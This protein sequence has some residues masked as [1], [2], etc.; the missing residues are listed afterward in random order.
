MAS[1]RRAT[2]VNGKRRVTGSWFYN[3]NADRFVIILYRNDRVTGQCRRIVV[4]G[5]KPEWG[6]WRLHD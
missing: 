5:D 2:W 4:A 1:E 6:N 3:W